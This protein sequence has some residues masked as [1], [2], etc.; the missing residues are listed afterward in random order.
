MKFTNRKFLVARFILLLFAFSFTE[1]NAQKVFIHPGILHNQ[2]SLDHIYEVVKKKKMAEAGS[3]QLLR[4]HPLA[5]ARYKMN[6]PY[7]TI[8]RDGEFRSTKSKWK[9]ILVR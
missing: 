4:D 7:R 2:A 3:Y 6:G 8:S 9:L 5:S 1:T